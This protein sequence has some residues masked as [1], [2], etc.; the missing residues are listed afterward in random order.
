MQ[1]IWHIIAERILK[2]K[3]KNLGLLSYPARHL[4]TWAA[5]PS[6]RL[7]P[8]CRMLGFWTVDETHKKVNLLYMD[9]TFDYF[10]VK[11]VLNML[12]QANGCSLSGTLMQLIYTSINKGAMS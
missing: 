5:G 3:I 4:A 10:S 9:W 12:S 6:I 2:N 8:A 11:K 7:L 1:I